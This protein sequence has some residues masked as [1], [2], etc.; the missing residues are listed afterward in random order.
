MNTD[1]L[2]Q[3]GDCFYFFTKNDKFF[4]TNQFCCTFYK[5]KYYSIC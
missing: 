2:N 5:C 1:T 4:D 3:S